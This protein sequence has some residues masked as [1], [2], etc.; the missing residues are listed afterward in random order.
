MFSLI[1]AAKGGEKEQ[2]E[3]EVS[4]NFKAVHL[5]YLSILVMK[6]QSNIFVS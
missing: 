5:T 1:N 3:K 6:E 2:Q 4:P